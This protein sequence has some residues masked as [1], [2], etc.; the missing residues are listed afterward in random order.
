MG[1]AMD[2]GRIDRVVLE[3]RNRGYPERVINHS[4]SRLIASNWIRLGLTVRHLRR[5]LDK[6]DC[7]RPK[8][9]FLY[10]NER[11]TATL[12]ALNETPEKIATDGDMMS[13]LYD[14][15]KA[16]GS[17]ARFCVAA[18]TTPSSMSVYR[19]K[20]Q[21][22]KTGKLTAHMIT[23]TAIDLGYLPEGTHCG[24]LFERWAD[25]E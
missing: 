4:E 14:R 12:K 3:F 24:Q 5:E 13:A 2:S 6:I 18:A 9:P 15:L 20:K 23:T 1:L 7:M 17:L 16:D 11:V 19:S 21:R 25:S 8:H 22:E 10:L